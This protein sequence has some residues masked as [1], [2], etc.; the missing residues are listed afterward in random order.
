MAA[1]DS[2]PQPTFEDLKLL[3]QVSELLTL[4]DLDHVMQ[5]VIRLMSD[6]VGAA[7]A[8]LFLHQGNSVDWKHIF[9]TRDLDPDQSVVV[10]EAVLNEGLAGWVVRQRRGTIVYDTLTDDRWKV[11]PDDPTEARSALCVPF[12]HN[13]EVLAVLTL[14]HPEPDSFDEHDLR[15][16]TIVA[17]QATVAIRNAQ[18]FNQVQQQQRQLEIML[19]A[20]P[21]IMLILDSGGTILMVNDMAQ[22]FLGQ[23]EALP[24]S[25]IIGQTISDFATQDTAL[26][27]VERI[28]QKPV[29]DT[30]FWTFATRSDRSDQD[31]QITMSTWADPDYSV[32]GY[33]V[34][35]HDV[36]TLRDLNRFK[37][38]MLKVVSHDLRNPIALIISAHDMLSQDLPADPEDTVT[39]EL[40]DIVK[41]ATDRMEGL[42]DDLLRAETS[43]YQAVA[44]VALAEEALANLHPLASQKNQ[45]MRLQD[46]VN[47]R[48]IQVDPMLV[49][50]AMENY[51]SNAI[52][53][54]PNNG[55]ITI[56]LYIEGAKLYF[57]VQDDGIGI[58]APDIPFVFDPY[59]R[60]ERP[61]TADTDGYGIGLNLVKSIINRHG[62]DVWVEST[63]GQGSLFGFWLPA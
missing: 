49:R 38:E 22:R 57:T 4:L 19:H 51:I 59:Y 61:E 17:N 60:V 12:V 5:R 36:T 46:E 7:K 40:L 9:L 2:T 25:Q 27:P 39:G 15:L 26:A 10:V 58:P 13:G 20:I 1:F 53:Y 47:E 21:D 3:T 11:F 48:V 37:D 56:R 8:S 6:A 45:T 16:I 23:G 33:V 32:D 62:G 42:L 14:V 44:P 24:R 31:L 34:I 29:D 43:S 28:V 52:K 30:R 54:T 41:G 18:L 50:E 55:T 63:E 35:M